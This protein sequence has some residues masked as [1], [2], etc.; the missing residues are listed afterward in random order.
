ML[1]SGASKISNDFFFTGFGLKT[2]PQHDVPILCTRFKF[3]F[4]F[5]KSLRQSVAN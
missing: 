4:F 3:N 2:V 5:G 1:D